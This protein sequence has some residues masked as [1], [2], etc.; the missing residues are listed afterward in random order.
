MMGERLG[1]QESLF[2]EFRF[3][4]HVTADH[5]LRGPGRNSSSA[6]RNSSAL[7]TPTSDPAGRS[8]NITR[9]M[10]GICASISNSWLC[11]GYLRHLGVTAVQL[12]P[13]QDTTARRGLGYKGVDYFSP[14]MSYQ[15]EDANEIARRLPARCVLRSVSLYDEL[16]HPYPPHHT[17]TQESGFGR[18]PPPACRCPTRRRSPSPRTRCG[19]RDPA[20]SSRTSAPRASA[21]S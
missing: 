16:K 19:G 4:D 8:R 12:L 9:S 14:E 18:P 6:S 10:R 21:T 17:R 15:L 20:P 11:L 5:L 7:P 2:Y 3:E 13:I 1:M